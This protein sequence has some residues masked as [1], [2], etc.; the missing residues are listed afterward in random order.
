M[1]ATYSVEDNKIR[2]YVGRVSREDYDALRA[3][4]FV[5]TPKQACD[6]V[7]P[8]T[9]TREDLA[10]EF[11][12]D[13]ADI[14]DEDY[15]PEE[16]AADR[17]ERFA[18]YRDKRTAEATGSADTFD[19]GPQAFG[20]QNRARAERQANRHDRHRTRAVSQWSKAEYWQT[21]TAG[22]I[23]NALY[24][25]SAKVRRGRILTLE[26]E[27]RKHEKTRA[28]YA[29]R[30]ALWSSVAGLEGADRPG[31]REA[32]GYNFTPESITPAL[33]RAY[34]IA[35]TSGMWSNYTHPRTGQTGRSMYDLLTDRADP[36]TPGEAAALWL[37]N[38]SDPT[39][40]DTHAAR[41]S[42][43]YENRL[44]YERAMLANEGGTA[45]DA[46]MVP[47]GFIGRHQIHGVN[48]SP[49]TGKVVSVKLLAEKPYW[50][51]EGAAPLTLQSFNVERMP[52]GAYRAPTAEELE[53]FKLATKAAKAEKKATTPKAPTLVNPTDEDAEKLQAIWNAE[54]KASHERRKAYGEV[55]V[56]SV[57]RM[58]QAEYSA[59]SK[60]DY[61]PCETSDVSELLKIR[62]T[63]YSGRDL[64]GRV[65]VFKVRTGSAGGSNYGACR[66]VVVL[67]DKPQKALP[68][69]DVEAT[70]EAMPSAETLFDRLGDIR[71]ALSERAA[72]NATDEQK[73]LLADAVYIGWAYSS[74]VTQRGFTEEGI[75]AYKRWE[76]EQHAEELE[77]VAV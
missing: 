70:R 22:V 67:T 34:G 43:H 35:N 12:P 76:T 44:S 59:R 5:A 62:Q 57:W 2:L 63:N 30:F 45:G 71:E 14:E 48:K 10:R 46:D 65:T 73:Q 25:A 64:A 66:R 31:V 41:W 26:A 39:D 50:R 23:A 21:R 58:T 40:P 7:A 20:H 75:A 17:A 4:G 55:P 51:G 27:Q 16:R 53:A 11:L 3:A 9:P 29:E 69:S 61:G 56:S 32:D 38:A 8:W 24:K 28:E 47:G 74:S 19:N 18:G 6:F 37:A 54:V 72:W 33:R 49:V 42:A 13:G 1:N 60:G 36:L 52:E 68:W 77:A 15:S